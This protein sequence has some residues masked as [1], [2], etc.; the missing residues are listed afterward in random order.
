LEIYDIEDRSIFSGA[1][2]TLS[3]QGKLLELEELYL[4]SN[5]STDY[6]ILAFTTIAQKYRLKTKKS[7]NL[8]YDSSFNSYEEPTYNSNFIFNLNLNLQEKFFYNRRFNQISYS[9]NPYLEAFNHIF[10]LNDSY[11][12]KEPAYSNGQNLNTYTS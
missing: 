1:P 4:L 9:F 3:L 2:N 10:T 6:N 8:I 5:L 12:Y 7:N 11:S